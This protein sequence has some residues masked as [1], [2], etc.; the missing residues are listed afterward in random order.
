MDQT[1]G[2]FSQEVQTI[3]NILFG[4]QLQEL[5][6][7]IKDLEEQAQQ[8]RAE[9]KALQKQLG[10][11]EAASGSTTEGGTGDA[12][13]DPTKELINKGLKGLFGN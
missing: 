6:S 8:L 7:R 12:G 5:F 13:G 11:G 3:R 2:K 4:E 1:E 10:G 9:N